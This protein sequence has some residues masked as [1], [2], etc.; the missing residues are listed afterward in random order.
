MQNVKGSSADAPACMWSPS[1]SSRFRVSAGNPEVYLAYWAIDWQNPVV[2]SARSWL[3]CHCIGV[4]AAHCSRG[5]NYGAEHTNHR[6]W[7]WS[8]M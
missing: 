5:I 3:L 8:S 4:S 7:C 6:D 2:G 1:L